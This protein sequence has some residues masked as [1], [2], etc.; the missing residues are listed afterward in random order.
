MT[1]HSGMGGSLGFAEESTH[2]VPVAPTRHLPLVKADL[3]ADPQ[4]IDSEAIVAGARLQRSA[5]WS[6]GR[7]MAGGDVGFELYD[8]SVGLLFKHIFGTVATT[9]SGP[10]THTF[11]PGD[12]DGKSLTFQEGVPDVSTGT[13]NP[14]TWSGSK[15]AEAEIACKAGELVTLG[16]TLASKYA[17]LYRQVTDGVTT[18]A[19]T[20]VTSATAAFSRDDV[21]KPISGTGIPAATTIASVESTT[22]ATLSAAATATATGLTFTFG[23]ALTSVSY[24]SNLMPM[25]FTGATVTIGGTAYLTEELSLKFNNGLNTE[26]FFLGDQGRA[27]SLEAAQREITGTI[28][29]DFFDLTAYRRF[30]SG[31]EA[32]VVF[33]F[34]RGT[35]TVTITM[36]VRFDGTTPSLDGAGLVKQELPFK[37]LGTTTDAGGITAVLVNGDSTP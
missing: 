1:L 24:P 32:A 35:S 12:I 37:V 21:G 3:K 11:T 33:R 8:R 29:S 23:L 15:I 16:L 19:S 2:A 13:S 5:Q 36:N 18:N 34:A 31:T 25:A 17:I 22:S 7:V 14:I 10:Y 9:G 30:V 28:N 27:E 4:P 26:R 20:T 6:S